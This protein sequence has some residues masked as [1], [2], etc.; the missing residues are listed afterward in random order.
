MI[1]MRRTS[2]LR[3]I[4][5]VICCIAL[6]VGLVLTA[7]SHRDSGYPL[8]QPQ[9]KGSVLHLSI[10]TP[11]SIVLRGLEAEDPM[12]RITSLRFVF[13]S[14]EKSVVTQVRELSVSPSTNLSDL[15]LPL[16]EGNY[17]L[18]VI[19]NPS[20]KLIARTVVGSPL[21]QL[22]GYDA[23]YTD[24]LAIQGS[25]LAVSLLNEQGLVTITS[26]AFSS[27]TPQIRIQLEPALARVLVYGEPRL[28]GGAKRGDAPAGYVVSPLA[29]YTAPLRPL[30]LLR[31][32]GSEVAGDGS[33]PED[34]Y[35]TSRMCLE[36]KDSAPRSLTG[37]LSHFA[38]DRMTSREGGSDVYQARLLPDEQALAAAVSNIHVY[39]RE[40]TLP[41]LAYLVGAIPS[42]I[43]R[44]PYIPAGL[45]LEENEGWMSFRGKYYA[46]SQLKEWIRMDSFDDPALSAAVKAAGV[47]EGSFTEPFEKGD[48]RFYY[49]GY[50]YYVVPIRH[51]DN[52]K[53]P[54]NT[55]IGRYGVVRG[56]EYRI[57]L[58]QILR[59]GTPVPPDLTA[60]LTPVTEEKNVHAVVSVRPIV[61]HS[62]EVQI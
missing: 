37:L 36:W 7:C 9:P 5:A 45:T 35:P 23:Y 50:N 46:E 22:T 48:L 54:T 52:T 4:P 57:H 14:P 16:P 53:A 3:Y 33:H 12:L 11:R 15:V 44:F 39:A 41:P 21:S 10:A 42:L 2:S 40:T 59:P 6:F 27:T 49:R 51:F 25:R 20:T 1:I 43:I 30:G 47:D 13:Y 28:E 38:L 55:S 32:G 19:A 34:R 24:E 61:V 17:K 26:A 58:T 62:S 8:P 60:N 31:T 29:R 18:A 56:A